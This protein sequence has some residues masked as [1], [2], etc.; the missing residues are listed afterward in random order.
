M[1][2][3]VAAKCAH[4]ARCRGSERRAVGRRSQASGGKTDASVRHLSPEGGV[5]GTGQ[6]IALARSLGFGRER[7][8]KCVQGRLCQ[9]QGTARL[10]LCL[11]M[12]G[13]TYVYSGEE[14]RWFFSV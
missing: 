10:L 3:H 14:M 9:I 1:L 2:V 5:T 13:L 8:L 7:A 4:R 11:G 6:A 12:V